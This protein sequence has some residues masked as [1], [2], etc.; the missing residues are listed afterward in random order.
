M[1]KYIFLTVSMMEK[2]SN[3]MIFS[4]YYLTLYLTLPHCDSAF[5]VQD[6][7]IHDGPY[8]L[9]IALVLRLHS[10]DKLNHI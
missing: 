7:N 4:V 9:A 5:G 10:L 1:L 3:S 6:H 2:F 8:K